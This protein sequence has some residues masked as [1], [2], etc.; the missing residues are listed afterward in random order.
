MWAASEVT[1]GQH[2]SSLEIYGGIWKGLTFSPE[3]PPPASITADA[4][5]ASSALGQAEEAWRAVE[6]SSL[7]HH[8]FTRKVT[9]RMIFF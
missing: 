9:P 7:I 3:S 2:F 8:W 5:I 4:A 1:S 6:E